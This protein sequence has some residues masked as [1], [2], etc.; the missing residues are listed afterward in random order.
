MT[1]SRGWPSE[2]AKTVAQN[3]AGSVIPPLSAEHAA[4]FAVDAWVLLAAVL[5]LLPVRS[6]LAQATNATANAHHFLNIVALRQERLTESATVR[7]PPPAD[8]PEIDK[9]RKHEAHD[10]PE[11]PMPAEPIVNDR[12]P[13]QSRRQEDES[14]YRPE[15]VVEDTAEPMGE[16]PEH[17]DDEA[18]CGQSQECHDARHRSDFLSPFAH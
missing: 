16:E 7:H 3:P 15:Q 5:S 2:S 18:R 12:I 11:R 6:V 8:R 17:C 1:M 10:R 4:D 14:D 9:E 13:E